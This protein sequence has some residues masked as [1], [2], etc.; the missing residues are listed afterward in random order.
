MSK[1]ATNVT[2]IISISNGGT[3]SAVQNFVDISGDQ[4]IGGTKVFTGDITAKI[5][6]KQGGTALQYLMADGSVGSSGGAGRTGATGS[7]GSIG[8]TGTKAHQQVA[9]I[10]VSSKLTQANRACTGSNARVGLCSHFLSRK[11]TRTS[12]PSTSKGIA[13]AVSN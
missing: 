9:T 3:G 10:H 5:I 6:R 12:T 11:R 8:L 4:N 13:K 1:S 2:G 7:Q